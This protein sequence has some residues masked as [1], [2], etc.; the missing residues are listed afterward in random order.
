MKIKQAIDTILENEDIT[1]SELALKLG[2]TPGMLS[3]YAS[4]AHYP[5][6]NVAGRIYRYYSIQ[7]EPFTQTSLSDEVEKQI[8]QENEDGN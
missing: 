6:L 1:R 8:D 5:R 4:N 3:H 7:V 2:I